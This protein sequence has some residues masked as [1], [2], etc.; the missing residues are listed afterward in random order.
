MVVIEM[1]KL[2][3]SITNESGRLTSEY[4]IECVDRQGLDSEKYDSR[5]TIDLIR[6]AAERHEYLS[7]FPEPPPLSS[8]STTFYLDN[9]KR[10]VHLNNVNELWQEVYSLLLGARLNFATARMLKRLEDEHSSA[11]DEDVNARFELHLDKMERFHLAV[12]EMARI[13]DL[14][15]RIVYEFLGDQFIDVDETKDGWEKKLT[16]DRMKEELNKKGKSKQNP[17]PALEAM[18][19]RAYQ[20]LVSVIRR[21][22]TPE[23]LELIRYRDIKTHRATPSVDHPELAVEVSSLG[24]LAAGSRAPLLA[25]RMRA[26]YQFLELYGIAKKVYAHLL[27]MLLELNE[28]V[29]A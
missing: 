14:I 22:R 25:A 26:E 10:A 28:V 16:W 23:V 12:F 19:E 27:R 7:D 18:D 17:H 8:V 29:H 1:T 3:V 9:F 6:A 2:K 21:Y 11:T 13:E 24:A 4:T 15:V 20:E 5:Y